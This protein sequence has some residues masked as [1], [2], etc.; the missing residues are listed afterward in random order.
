LKAGCI[1]FSL[2][3][4]GLLLAYV[5]YFSEADFGSDDAV[6]NLLAGA[7]HDQG[8]LIVPRGWVTANSDLIFPS[9]ALMMLAMLPWLPNGFAVHAIAACALTIVLLIMLGWGLVASGRS[10][11]ATAFV[12]TILATGLSR[13]MLLMMFTQTTYFWW[14]FEFLTSALI[15]QTYYRCTVPMHKIEPQVLSGLLLS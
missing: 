7:L 12:V 1:A 6:F 3:T 4:V 15:I 13:G 10:I 5:G 14:P 11:L 8:R 9:A 2:A